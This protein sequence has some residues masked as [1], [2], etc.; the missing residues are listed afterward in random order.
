MEKHRVWEHIDHERQYL[1]DLLAGLDPDQW[2]HPSLCTGWRVREVAAH[3]VSSPATSPGQAALALLRAKGNLNKMIDTMAHEAAAAS[4]AE[5]VA[6]YDQYA[7]SRRRPPGTVVLDPLCDVLVHTQD[8][9]RPLGID[10]QPDP[11]VV[12]L[13]LSRARQAALAFGTRALV[14]GHRFEATD[15]DWSAGRGDL[16]RGPA[17]ELLLLLTGRLT[18]DQVRAQA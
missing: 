14:R 11:E 17:L 8:I 12:A 16:L 2:E 18:A 9:A 4:A 1:R 3:V 7:G 6:R 15:A 10:Y 13:C 5:I